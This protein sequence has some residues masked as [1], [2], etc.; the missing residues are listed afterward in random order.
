MIQAR[1]KLGFY[2]LLLIPSLCY[3]IKVFPFTCLLMLKQGTEQLKTTL[4]MEVLKIEVILVAC[5]FSMEKFVL[6]NYT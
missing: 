3:G 2:R 6:I 4:V 1:L 5:L